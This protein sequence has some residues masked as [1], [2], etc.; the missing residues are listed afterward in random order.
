MRFSRPPT[1]PHLQ[2]EESWLLAVDLRAGLGLAALD[3]PGLRTVDV[4]GG[5]PV[6]IVG[7]GRGDGGAGSFLDNLALGRG[8]LL[9]GLATLALLGEVGCD[10]DSVEEVDDTNEAGQEEE[11]EEDAIVHSR[12][13]LMSGCQDEKGMAR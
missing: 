7:G 3:L 12:C 13:Q 4:V 5:N 6:S 8:L 1:P 9:A 2:A 11:V 10:P